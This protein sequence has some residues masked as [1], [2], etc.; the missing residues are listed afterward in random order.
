MTSITK[1][2]IIAEVVAVTPEQA[3]EWLAVNNNNRN[4]RE[5]QVSLYA[6]DMEQGNWLMTGEAI[7]IAA[8]GQLLDGQHR[9]R[10]VVKSGVTVDMLVLFNVDES[11]Q[12]VMDTGSKRTAADH[13]G[14]LGHKNVNHLASVAKM[15]VIYERGLLYRDR[16]EWQVSASEIEE[17]VATHPDLVDVVNSH[18][19]FR[20]K[21]DVRPSSLLV[22]RLL[23]LRSNAIASEEFWE[24]LVSLANLPEGSPI[25]ALSRRLSELRRTGAKVDSVAE[26]ALLM[27][28]WNAWRE[29][30]SL[31]KLPVAVG[32]KSV[33]F[34][35][36]A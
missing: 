1:T 26:L 13:L 2:G 22:A 32:G 33:R 21:V 5:R 14:M 29:G 16:T 11:A 35:Y 19:R 15:M 36:V 8:S 18:S 10:A 34:T 4:I 9:L 20:K 27:R 24:S 7:K 17:Y 31:I 25:L 28:T 3:A 30:R 6:S 12:R 23:T